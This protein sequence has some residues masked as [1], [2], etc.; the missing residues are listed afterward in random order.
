MLNICFS[1]ST[2]WD[3][4][5][6][7][8][9]CALMCI[10]H[11]MLDDVPL[12]FMGEDVMSWAKEIKYLGVMVQSGRD[13]TVNVNVN[14]RKFLGACFGMF[15]RCG[16]LSETVL[17][18]LVLKKCLP[19][20]VYG[21]ECVRLKA[22]QKQRLSVAFNTAIRRVFK[23]SKYTSVK[24]VIFYVG[25]K[26]VKVLLDERRC[27]LIKSC[28]DGSYGV[29]RKCARLVGWTDDFMRIRCSYGVHESLP[30]SLI[31]K[32]FYDFGMN[33]VLQHF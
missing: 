21:M 14:C 7:V 16:G 26:P 22:A 29:L 32:Y 31:K 5:F 19:A 6:N 18:E 28:L 27:L 20:L 9:K 15:Q 4:K 12:M 8:K 1:Y 17:C 23:L 30:V 33:M 3:M 25:G 13:L 11:C 2:D 10:G 24:N